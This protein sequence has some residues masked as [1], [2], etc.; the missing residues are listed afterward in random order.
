MQ[1]KWCKTFTNLLVPPVGNLEINARQ[2]C[3]IV[4]ERKE[5]LLRQSIDSRD[6]Y[7]RLELLLPLMNA[8]ELAGY[9]IHQLCKLTNRCFPANMPFV[10]QELSMAIARKPVEEVVD[11]LYRQGNELQPGFAKAAFT[12]E[13]SW[14]LLRKFISKAVTPILEDFYE[15]VAALSAAVSRA[16]C[17]A[18]AVILTKI[19]CILVSIV[20]SF[21][22]MIW[23][24]L[25]LSLFPI[26]WLVITIPALC[27][28]D[29]L[30]TISSSARLCAALLIWAVMPVTHVVGL[31]I[32]IAKREFSFETLACPAMTVF[33]T[34]CYRRLVDLR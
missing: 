23:S 30:S 13:R 32:A 20:W 27:A 33:R 2:L 10:F 16:K 12:N 25:A 34:D 7:R 19:A 14:T 31:V 8:A 9:S 26:Y 4:K 17:P 3:A 1:L 15:S 18:K 6:A 24:S 22:A 21:I 29:G 11:I 28:P 5:E